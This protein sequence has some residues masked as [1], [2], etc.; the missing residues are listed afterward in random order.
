[1]KIFLDAGHGGRD[2]G[3]I[4]NDLQEKDIVLQMALTIG[5]KLEAKYDCQALYS[6]TTDTFLDLRPRALMANGQGADFFL[7]L[8]INSH[9]TAEPNGYEDF[10]LTAAN[11][12]LNNMRAKFHSE[13]SRVWERHGRRNRGRKL[14]NFAVLRHARM[15]AILVENGFIRNVRDA[16]LLRNAEFMDE[17]TDAHVAGLA[18]AMGLAP[19]NKTQE[20]KTYRVKPGDT[21]WSIA[22]SQLGNGTRWVELQRINNL[23]SNVVTAGQELRIP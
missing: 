20:Q 7:S 10:I 18:I 12:K 21:L 16:Q 5:R 17:L 13:V 2:P 9:T 23:T 1:M 22:A 15:P 19:K 4:G 14:A 8:H 11:S 6:R 3:A